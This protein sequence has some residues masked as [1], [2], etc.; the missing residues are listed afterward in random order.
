MWTFNNQSLD[1]ADTAYTGYALA[2]H[3]DGCYL[4]DQAGYVLV[5]I[6]LGV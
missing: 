2:S 6:R 3:T 5:G 4:H 1:H